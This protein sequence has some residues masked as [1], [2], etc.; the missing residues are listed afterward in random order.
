MNT[1]KIED[2]VKGVR[3]QMNGQGAFV[4]R[5]S[6]NRKPFGEFTV[7]MEIGLK[8]GKTSVSI[9]SY[10]Y[11]AFDWHKECDTLE[12]AVECLEKEFDEIVK[13]AIEMQEQHDA[14]IRK[15]IQEINRIIEARKGDC[16]CQKS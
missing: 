10:D 11:K 6:V 8:N 2:K 1:R 13:L 16:V 12:G 14:V 4:G 5:F 9:K 3:W 7:K 15:A